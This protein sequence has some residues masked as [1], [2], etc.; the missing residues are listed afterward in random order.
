MRTEQEMFDLI[1]KTAREDERIRGVCLE[2][3]RVNPEIPRDL[4]QDY[5]IVYVV[6]ETTP[7]REDKHW[8]DRFGE[9]LYMQYP[10]EGPYESSDLNECYGWL[11]QLADGNRLDLHV[12]TMEGVRKELSREKLYKVLLD[13]DQ[14]IPLSEAD[15]SCYWVQEPDQE[16]FRF[17]ANEFWWCLNNVGKGLWR[18]EL[19]YV[20]DMIHFHVRPMLRQL[21]EWKAGADHGFSISVGKSGKYLKKYLPA[22]LYDRYLDTYSKAEGEDLWKSVFVMCDLFERTAEELSERLDLFYDQTEGKNS[23]RYLEKVC[24][25]PKDACEIVLD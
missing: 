24:C 22:E 19:P 6:T 1:L 4:F 18:E 10:E 20:M 25:L 5:D 11:I 13:K 17:T 14:V 2:G 23:R 12:F 7:F 8:I 21:L 16:T 3:S 9:R 15:A